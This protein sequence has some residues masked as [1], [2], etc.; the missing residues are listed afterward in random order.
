MVG[1]FGSYGMPH[2]LSE[3]EQIHHFARRRHA[4]LDGECDNLILALK[5][6]NRKHVGMVVKSLDEG[7]EER[8]TVAH[9]AKAEVTMRELAKNKVAREIVSSKF[10]LTTYGNALVVEGDDVLTRRK[11]QRIRGS[12]PSYMRI[13]LGGKA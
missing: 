3:T 13:G 11:S 5:V 2:E 12:H 7:M 10:D 1:W 6:I 9:N 8:I 4:A